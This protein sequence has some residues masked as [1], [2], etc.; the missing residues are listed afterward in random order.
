M[1]DHRDEL[2]NELRILLGQIE[3]KGLRDSC[4]KRVSEIISSVRSKVDRLMDTCQVCAVH[5]D[6]MHSSS[7]LRMLY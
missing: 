3:S 5:I 1:L 4:K 6:G 7:D 2:E